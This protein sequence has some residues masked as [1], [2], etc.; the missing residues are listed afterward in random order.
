M[1]KALKV[2]KN[3]LINASLE[4]VWDVL[5][6]PEKIKGYLYGTE[7]ITDWKVGSP[8]IF[9]GE[10]DGY[11][12]K[13]KGF[14]VENIVLQSIK[15][16]YWSGFS[17]LEEKLEN[18]SLVIYQLKEISDNQVEFTWGQEGFANEGGMQHSENGLPSLLEQIKALAEK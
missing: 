1:N 14:I 3:I 17:G 2:S 5:T 8:I 6:N 11:K 7:T 18:H 12:Y 13:D 9:Q 15:Y 4:Q 16:S 10:Y